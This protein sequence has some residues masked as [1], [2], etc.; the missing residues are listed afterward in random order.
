MAKVA[1]I[2][3]DALF[4]ALSDTT[5]LRLLNLLRAGEVCVCDL[6]DGLQIPQPTASRHLAALRKAGLVTVRKDGLWCHYSL[7]RPQN[8]LHAKLLECLE[9]CARETTKLGSDATRLEQVRKAR[10]CCD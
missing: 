5:R 9:L 6:V 10:G 3:P 7:A 2:E 1:S 4:A 8:A